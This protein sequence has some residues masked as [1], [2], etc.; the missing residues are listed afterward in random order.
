MLI[1]FAKSTQPAIFVNTD[2]ISYLRHTGTEEGI[3]AA[4][5]IIIG[6]PS[7]SCTSDKDIFWYARAYDFEFE[8]EEDCDS[9]WNQLCALMNYHEIV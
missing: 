4:I 6:A 1:N 9:A 3:L 7:D 2:Q 8:N 5:E